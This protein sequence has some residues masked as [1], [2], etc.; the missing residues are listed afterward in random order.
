MPEKEKKVDSKKK[1]AVPRNALRKS[2]N[3]VV[4][5]AAVMDVCCDDIKEV[6]KEVGAEIAR[7]GHVLITGATSGVPFFSAIG[8]DEAGGQNIGFSPAES[9]IEHI[10][11]YKLPTD[12]FDIIVYTGSDYVGRDI[13]MTKSAD[14]VIIVCGRIGTLHEFTTAVEC[15]KP[16]GILEK[17]GG[18]ADKIRYILDE[19]RRIKSPIVMERDPKILVEKLVKLIEADE[20]KANK[21]LNKAKKLK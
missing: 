17:S 9:K 8:C 7:Q 6:S 12:P 13:I 15:G 14:G 1:K 4:S 20:K 2:F 18:M 11:R 16:V 5:G 21:I 19:N 10:K 3:I